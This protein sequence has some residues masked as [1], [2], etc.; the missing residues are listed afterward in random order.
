MLLL[1]DMKGW[2]AK[3]GRGQRSAAQSVSRREHIRRTLQITVDT[4]VMLADACE[5]V[6]VLEVTR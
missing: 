1:S 2:R 6:G 5:R 4:V 3:A